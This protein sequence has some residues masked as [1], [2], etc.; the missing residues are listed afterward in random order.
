MK[1]GR[2]VLLAVATSLVVAGIA[3]IPKVSAGGVAPSYVASPDVYKLLSENEHFRVILATWKPGQRDAW[4]AHEG[5]LVAYRLTDCTMR[6]HAPDGKVTQ[7][8]PA[9]GHLPSSLTG[10]RKD[11]PYS[12]SSLDAL[13]R[14]TRSLG[15]M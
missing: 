12:G 7:P 8:W 2:I 15:T 14:K 9:H 13:V 5:P 4:H 3:T 10:R 1:R 6:A 11:M